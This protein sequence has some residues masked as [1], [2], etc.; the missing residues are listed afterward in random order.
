MTEKKLTFEELMEHILEQRGANGST[1]KDIQ[2]LRNQ[3]NSRFNALERKLF[4]NRVTRPSSML[5]TDAHMEDLPQRDILGP[6]IPRI[7]TTRRP[8][9]GFQDVLTHSMHDLLGAHESEVAFL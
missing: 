6:H 9:D 8:T 4:G 5:N 2:R 1:V 3:V 7:E